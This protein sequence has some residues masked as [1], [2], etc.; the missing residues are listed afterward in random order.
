MTGQWRITG[1][2]MAVSRTVVGELVQSVGDRQEKGPVNID[3]HRVEREDRRTRPCRDT[4]EQN[5]LGERASLSNSNRIRKER[6][7]E[8]ER[9]KTVQRKERKREKKTS[10]FLLG[11]CQR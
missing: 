5:C 7:T 6:Q 4:E 1:E 3:V 11:L 9:E 8:R 10:L 2:P